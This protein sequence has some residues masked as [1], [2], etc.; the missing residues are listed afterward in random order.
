[1]ADISAAHSAAAAKSSAHELG[2]LTEVDL[3]RERAIDAGRE[4]QWPLLEGGCRLSGLS[5]GRAAD[6]RD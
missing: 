6:A 1:V 3:A 4:D 5:S 2:R